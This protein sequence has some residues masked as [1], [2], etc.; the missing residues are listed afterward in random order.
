MTARRAGLRL[1]VRCDAGRCAWLQSDN[2]CAIESPSVAM[3][4]TAA[5]RFHA[6]NRAMRMRASAIRSPAMLRGRFMSNGAA[7]YSF[8]ERPL[9]H[10]DRRSPSGAEPEIMPSRSF[11]RGDAVA[12]DVAVGRRE[13]IARRDFFA[14][15]CAPDSGHVV[16]SRKG[17]SWR[18]TRATRAGRWWRTIATRR[19][20]VGVIATRLADGDSAFANDPARLSRSGVCFVFVVRAR[21]CGELAY[22]VGGAHPSL[23]SQN[24]GCALAR[25]IGPSRAWSPMGD[26]AA[27]CVDGNN[28]E[29][30]C[31]D[32]V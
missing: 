24:H 21:E 4:A 28:A 12:V 19:V 5:T 2:E 20:A 17:P 31:R 1:S 9:Y 27:V 7:F 15:R 29:P 13:C 23:L 8:R 6:A 30:R 22:P 3:I 10:V 26:C 25:T 32:A 11:V 16:A 14:T 18:R